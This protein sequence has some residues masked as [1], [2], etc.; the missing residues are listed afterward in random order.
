MTTPE[1]GRPEPGPSADI[2][3]IEA[4]IEQ[5]RDELGQTVAALSSKLDVKERSR[6]KAAETKER[7]A[8]KADTLRH[9]AT[10]NPSRTVP[11]AIVVLAVLA[12]I[13]IWRRRR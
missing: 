12:G 5:T 6:Q 4:D 3:E 9:T 7:V 13:V 11:I 10:D 2:A 8:E 1:S